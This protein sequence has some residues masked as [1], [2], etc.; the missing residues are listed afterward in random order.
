MWR[1]LFAFCIPFVIWYLCYFTQTD[2]L[3]THTLIASSST[4]ASIVLWMYSNHLADVYKKERGV[5]A[6]ARRDHL[7]KNA[8]LD[9]NVGGSPASSSFSR[10]FSVKGFSDGLG[11]KEASCAPALSNFQNEHASLRNQ[12]LERSVARI[13]PVLS[14][15]L[16]I[17]LGTFSVVLYLRIFIAITIIP[18]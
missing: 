14:S 10:N 4:I 3:C 11:L 9:E 16:S 6:R 7:M 2:S 8:L 18:D 17:T 12:S 5:R 1:E 15:F 13:S